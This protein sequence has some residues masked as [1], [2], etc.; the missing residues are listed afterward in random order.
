[1]VLI[2]HPPFL[3]GGS[4]ALDSRRL[5]GVGAGTASAVCAAGAFL[6]IKALGNSEQPI[7]MSMWFHSVSAIAAVVPLCLG[8]PDPAMLPSWQEMLLLAG[9]VA[10][11]FFGQLLISRGFQ[12]L[13]PSTAASINLTQVVHAHLLSL[14][15][16]RDAVHWY[17]FAG[18]ALVAAGVLLAQSDTASEEGNKPGVDVNDLAGL[19]PALEGERSALLHAAGD[20]DSSQLVC[21]EMATPRADA[22]DALEPG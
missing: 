9:V 5:L 4:K 17:S 15:A 8:W 21:H 19:S 12:L 10:T 6:S 1:V 11:S 2:T 16:L 7:V 20:A 3:F 13:K 14:V 18:T 22:A